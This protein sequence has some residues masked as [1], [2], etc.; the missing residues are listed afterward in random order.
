MSVHL[1]AL[2]LD[3]VSPERLAAFWAAI[4]G[5]QIDASGRTL[6]GLVPTD[7]EIRFVPESEPKAATRHR[8]HFDL[9]STSPQDQAAT[10]A[11]AMRLGG[12]HVDVG[13][14]GDEGH[15]VLGDPEDNEFCV[16]ES[17]NG[18][19][20]N[21]ARIGAVAGDGMPDTGYFWSR[22]LGWPL[23]WDQDDETA[24]QSPDGGV[25]ITWGGPPIAAKSARNRLRWV[26]EAGRSRREELDRL[27]DLGASVVGERP[28]GVELADPEGNEFLLT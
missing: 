13:Q 1:V 5:R 27:R 26:L 7:F 24:I 10:V 6:P 15:V 21:T 23:V 14:R 16:I 22:V 20:A 11:L 9:T 8:M 25:K 28:A 3:A 17:G 4:L 18:F 2:E 19:L 12:H